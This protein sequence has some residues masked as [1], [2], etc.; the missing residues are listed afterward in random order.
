L[1]PGEERAGSEEPAAVRAF[2][3]LGANLGDRLANLQ[4]AADLL[5]QKEG[6]AIVASSRVYETEPV[7]GPPQP[8]Y[9]NSVIEA[10]TTRSPRSL[11]DACQ[12]VE[13]VMGRER[14]ERWGPRVIDVDLLTYGRVRVAEPGLQIPH[15]RMHERGFVLLPLLELTEDPPLPGGRSIGSVRFGGDPMRGVVLFGPPLA[16]R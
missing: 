14:V 16:L 13:R 1:R 9:L 2:L 11:L 3:G 15:P 5:G 4:R 7:G 6:I 12:E 10:L 8:D